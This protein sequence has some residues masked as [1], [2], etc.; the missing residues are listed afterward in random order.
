MR[1]PYDAIDKETGTRR[2][3]IL[4]RLLWSCVCCLVVCCLVVLSCLVLSCLAL[5]CFGH[6]EMVYL[7]GFERCFRV[8]HI[9]ATTNL[10]DD[11]GNT[12]KRHK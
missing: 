9:C 3:P 4:I 1:W 10:L 11:R 2:L 8:R 7:S 12:K 5:P 6:G